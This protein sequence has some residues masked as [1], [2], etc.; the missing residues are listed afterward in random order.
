[1]R[2]SFPNAVALTDLPR[3]SGPPQTRC[4][5]LATCSSSPPRAP[6]LRPAQSRRRWQPSMPQS[7]SSECWVGKVTLL[8]CGYVN[9]SQCGSEILV[10]WGD[11]V[12]NTVYTC[13][14]EN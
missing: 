9:V 5:P 13:Q 6:T 4:L 3:R 7:T 8:C 1:M 14:H 10:K 11:D 12:I 2:C